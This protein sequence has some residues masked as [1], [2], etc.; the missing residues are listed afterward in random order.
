MSVTGSLAPAYESD[1]N[2]SVLVAS[3]VDTESVINTSQSNTETLSS[4]SSDDRWKLQTQD[5]QLNRHT[6]L[7]FN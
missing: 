1:T 7:Y 4:V 5:H 3:L 6:E 2:R